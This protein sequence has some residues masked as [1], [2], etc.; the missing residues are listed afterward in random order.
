MWEAWGDAEQT[1]FDL[2]DIVKLPTVKTEVKLSGQ[3]IAVLAV[4]IT[5]VVIL[6]TKPR[7]LFKR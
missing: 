4:I 1:G 2:N 5:T 7:W 6:V 3:V